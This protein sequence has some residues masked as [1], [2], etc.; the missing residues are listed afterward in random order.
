MRQAA[1]LAFQSLEIHFRYLIE[2]LAPDELEVLRRLAAHKSVDAD[3][4]LRRLQTEGFIQPGAGTWEPMSA[5]FTEILMALPQRRLGE[6]LDS[7]ASWQF[8]ATVG[9]KTFEVAVQ[10]AIEIATGKYLA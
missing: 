7:S 5:L 8:I 6:V 3:R 2:H 10:K 1:L 4:V 9:K